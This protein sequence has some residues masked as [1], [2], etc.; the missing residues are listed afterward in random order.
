MI[1]KP[2]VPGKW[3]WV[4]TSGLQF[5]PEASELPRATEY[6]VE[7]PAGTRALDGSTMPK[8][9]VLRFSTV[10]PQLLS[11][12]PSSQSSY[13][14]LEPDT[15]FA[16]RF[17]QPV[18]EAEVA[19]ATSLT[20]GDPAA[21]VAFDVKRPDPKNEQ[22]VDIV[23]RA[24]LPL[25]APVQ[26]TTDATLRGREGP[27]TAGSRTPSRSPPTGR[28]SSSGSPAPRTRRTSAAR[29]RTG[30]RSSSATP[31]NSRTSSARSRSI[32]RRGAL[33]ALV[34]RRRRD[35]EHPGVG[36]F[37]PGRTYRA[38]IAAG[39]LKDVHG[40]PLARAM[41]ETVAFDDYW[42]RAEIGVRGELF[43]AAS[44]RPIS[45][46]SVNVNAIELV[47]A[48]LDES[49][50]L[51]ID[52]A[53]PLRFANLKGLPGAKVATIRPGAAVN[54]P[55]AHPVDP[56]AV[57]GG[58]DKRGPLVIGISYS[59]REGTAAARASESTSIV[60]IT[61][62][63]ISAKISQR[64]SL[65]WVTR[66]STGAPVAGATVSLARPGG[67]HLIDVVTDASGFAPIPEAAFVSTG[68]DDRAIIFARLGDDWAYHRVRDTVESYR[69]GVWAD[70]SPDHPF[71]MIFS[72]RGIYR[73]GDTVQLKGIFREE[74]RT[75]TATPAGRMVDLDVESSDG[76][77]VT[78]M[79]LSLS[80]F[81]T[82]SAQVKLPPPAAS[83]ATASTRVSRA[84]RAATPTSAP[85]SRSPST[86]PPSSRPRCRAIARATSA[87]I[88]RAGRRAATTSSARR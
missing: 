10:R 81:G 86:A 83:G 12:R 68:I 34:R 84:A 57:L 16:L 72:D 76:Q 37:V 62:L 65:V 13:D 11:V 39:A 52:D 41:S 63:G 31:S 53:H 54:K 60:S 33:A 74:A 20:A 3:S 61:D 17:N 85:T 29:P 18:D 40:Q 87:A 23:P 79:S 27:L 88:R 4:G 19:R 8:P 48:P 47:T 38:S 75:G 55:A 6:T 71:G 45:V 14:S 22:L 26:I 70:L 78:K 59:T 21:R 51:G 7:V 56:A 36:R 1:I 49:A 46:A 9:Y 73:P 44:R 66:L 42:P 2:A 32:P 28:S 50:I 5:V 35:R 24:K 43:D 82:L 80:A 67:Q 64:G 25:S 58:K 15:S 77:P 30:S 69:F